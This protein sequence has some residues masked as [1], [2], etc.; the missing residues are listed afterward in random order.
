MESFNQFSSMLRIR[1][2]EIVPLLDCA[3]E[4]SILRAN[5]DG[6]VVLTCDF[7]DAKLSL[8][9]NLSNRP[10]TIDDE[11]KIHLAT[12]KIIYATP[13]KVMEPNV[14][15]LPPW[16]VIWCKANVK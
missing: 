9:A 16:S 15:Q 11:L 6:T 10:K 4:A 5:E 14:E 8:I 7:P 1:Q 12:S 13:R 3:A 2:E